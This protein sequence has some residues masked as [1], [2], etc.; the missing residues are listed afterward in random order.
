MSGD[1]I[2]NNAKSSSMNVQES[3]SSNNNDSIPK[4]SPDINGSEGERTKKRRI[5]KIH[6]YLAKQ[7][8]NFFTDKISKKYNKLGGNNIFL[9]LFI[10]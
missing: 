6:T 9:K 8:R 2:R 7:F 5:R 4:K 10:S 1:N 3:T